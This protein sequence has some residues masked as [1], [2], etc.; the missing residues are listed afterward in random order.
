MLNKQNF[1]SLVDEPIVI[2]PQV[3]S[4]HVWDAE[5]DSVVIEQLL[6]QFTPME[7]E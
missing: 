2:S 4:S 7:G 1:H 6:D 3:R 5:I